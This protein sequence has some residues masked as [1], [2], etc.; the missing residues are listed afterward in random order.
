[1]SGMVDARVL[2]K[3]E[4][5]SLEEFVRAHKQVRGE[6]MEKLILECVVRSALIAVFSAWRFLCCMCSAAAFAMRSGPASWS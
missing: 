3:S 6:V 5:D 4:M 1:M 2:S